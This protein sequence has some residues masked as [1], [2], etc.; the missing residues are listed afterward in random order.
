MYPQVCLVLFKIF[1]FLIYSY[2]FGK[3]NNKKK[4]FLTFLFRQTFKNLLNFLKP[5]FIREN[6]FLFITVFFVYICLKSQ[7]YAFNVF[8]SAT[9]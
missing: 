8:F 4:P 6:F 7:F 3:F 1:L 2:C 5:K 9:N